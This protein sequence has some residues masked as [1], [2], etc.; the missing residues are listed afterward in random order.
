MVNFTKKVWVV[1][2]YIKSVNKNVQ[3]GENQG[4]NSSKD[5]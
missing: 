1:D 2:F 4:N 5:V 3:I